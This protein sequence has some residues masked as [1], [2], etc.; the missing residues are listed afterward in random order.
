MQKHS[1][2]SIMTYSTSSPDLPE[3]GIGSATGVYSTKGATLCLGYGFEVLNKEK[4][5]LI[6]IFN[7]GIGYY[8]KSGLRNP[9]PNVNLNSNIQILNANYDLT[10]F[11]EKFHHRFE[12]ATKMTFSKDKKIQFFMQPS[13]SLAVRLKDG[14]K[15]YAFTPV[16]WAFGIGFGVTFNFTN[17]K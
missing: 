2:N 5:Q 15:Q 17:K 4:F 13:Y 11:I 7:Y 6:P 12:L 9:P 16:Y 3:G 8:Y 14:K 10:T 1:N